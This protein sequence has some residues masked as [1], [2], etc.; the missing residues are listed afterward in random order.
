MAWNK[1]QMG[2]A[3]VVLLGINGVIGGGLFLLPSTLYE[4]GGNLTILAIILAG[5][6]ATLI[7]MHYAVMSS[8]IDDD[9]GAW[10]YTYQAFGRFPGFLVGWFGWLFGVI[11]ISAESAAFLKTLSGIVP[12]VAQPFIYNTLTITI[13]AILI[14]I[15]LFGTGI[16]SYVDDVASLI[17]ILVIAAVF[18]AVAT[19]LALGQADN[20]TMTHTPQVTNFSGAF[21]NAFYMFTGFSLIPIAAKEMKNPGK[22]LPRAILTVMLVTTAIFVLMQLVAVTVL[23]TSLVHSSLPVADIIGTIMGRL[24][25][26]VIITGMTLSI[27]GVAIANSFNSPIELA[28]MASEHGFLPAKLAITNKFGAPVL[29]ILVTMTIAG[30]LLLSGSY[31]F[32]IKLIVLSDFMQYLGTIFSSLK[33]RHDDSLPKGYQ[34]PGGKWLTYLTLIV[35]AYLFTTF[36]L[37]TVLVGIGFGIL[38][39]GV[40]YWNLKQQPHNY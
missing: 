9:G 16:S 28:S 3:S 24:G 35:V 8:K 26:T 23:G 30:G 38:G 12:I 22:M 1:K 20:I 33:L 14:I 2:F 25:R 5:I 21:G 19:W 27:I 6:A 31:L 17:K 34:L 11:T 32:L 39:V 37:M 10:T 40:Y 18:I 4:Q 29:A 36:S 13:M 15:N 7:A